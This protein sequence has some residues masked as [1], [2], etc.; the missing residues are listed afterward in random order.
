MTFASTS[1]SVASSRPYWRSGVVPI[2]ASSVPGSAA[3]HALLPPLGL[4]RVGRRAFSAR[5][6][7]SFACAVKALEL[8]F[9]RVRLSLEAVRVSGPFVGPNGDVARGPLRELNQD[10]RHCGDA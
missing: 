9:E 2:V 10:R 3:R 4:P 6:R 7:D 8:T 1:G 5:A